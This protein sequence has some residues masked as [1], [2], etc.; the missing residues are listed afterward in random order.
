MPK[1]TQLKEFCRLAELKCSGNKS[2]IEDRIK[3]YLKSYKFAPRYLRGLNNQEKF[4]K[5]F[6]IKYYQLLQ[7][8]T[9][10]PYYSPTPS[11]KRYRSKT[12]KSPQKISKYT[13]KWNSLYDA[14]SLT[15]KSKI[16]GV[17]PK[18]LKEVYNRGLAAW[19]GSAHRPGAT[20][21]QWGVSRVNSFLTCGK[22]WS[23]PDH[24]LAIKAMENS[25]KA[26]NF[27]KHC[28]KKSLG[29]R[30]PSR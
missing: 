15:E 18:I 25:P 12:K 28:N 24:K 13:K 23:F 14:R 6:E 5:K 17:S 9:K 21:H 30:T 20:Q 29:K 11:D 3:T 1:L 8:K 4:E 10:K 26:R 16:S 22:T 19:R 7:K 2:E 27:W